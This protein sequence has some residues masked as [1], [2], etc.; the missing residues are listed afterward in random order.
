MGWLNRGCPVGASTFG[1][2]GGFREASSI[3]RLDRVAACEAVGP[4]SEPS[5]RL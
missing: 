4:N 5:K 2:R 1:D 3:G